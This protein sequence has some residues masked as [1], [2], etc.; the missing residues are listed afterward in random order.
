M[1]L[2]LGRTLC[3]LGDWRVRRSLGMAF[4]YL[5]TTHL[6]GLLAKK[7]ILRDRRL[8]GARLDALD[9]IPP[10]LE[11]AGMEPGQIDS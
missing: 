8:A 3:R 10:G 4:P 1:V 5:V 6:V 7:H 2:T 9:A 11:H